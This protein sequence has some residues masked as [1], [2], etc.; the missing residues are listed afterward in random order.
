MLLTTILTSC[1]V[2]QSIN[3]NALQIG[4]TKEEAQ[5]ALKIKP[6]GI[7]AAKNFPEAKTT[8][9][10]VYYYTQV[11]TN[12]FWLYFNNNKLSKWE[13]ASAH[14]QPYLDDLVPMR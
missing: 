4:M 6:S 1:S 10:V 13:P 5:Q 12:G 3:T 8:V 7:V 9:E 11:D 14:H 2:L